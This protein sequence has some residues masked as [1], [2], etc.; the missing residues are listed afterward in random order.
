MAT[1]FGRKGRFQAAKE[2]T[3][4]TN[5]YCSASPVTDGERVIAWFGSAGL[6][7]WNMEGQEQ[8]HLDLGKQEHIW[9]YGSSPILDGDL[10]ILNF[11]P[12][13]RSFIVAVD[14]RTGKE[15]WR[16]DVPPPD[17]WEGS[18]A[19]QKW[20]GSWSTP[21][22]VKIQEQAEVIIA[23]PGAVRALQIETGR[24]LWHCDGLNPLIYANP[25]VSADVIAAMG[26]FGGYSIGFKAPLAIDGNAIQR[27]WQVKKSTQ[28]IGSGVVKDGLIYMPNESGVIQCLKAETGE[29]VWEERLHVPNGQSSTWS[30]FV[31]AGD[32]LYLLTKACDTVILKIGSKY[33]QIAVNPLNDSLIN[34]SIAVSNGELFIRTHEHLWCIAEK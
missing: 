14:K 21:V 9:G 17:V 20:S 25:L 29:P 10:C 1:L 30:S 19:S 34:S 6:W 11:G 28:R 13:D 16:T 33:E 22:V 26:G 18:G 23:L 7:C 15:K 32:R 8:W 12:G 3:H 24:E 31:L 5:P 2:L 4:E 27:L